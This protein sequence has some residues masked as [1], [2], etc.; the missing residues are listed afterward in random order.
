M[1]LSLSLPRALL[2][3]LPAILAVPGPASGI[4]VGPSLAPS[5]STE[6][7]IHAE[8]IGDRLLIQGVFVNEGLTA[9]TLRYEL[10]VRRSGD[11]GTTRTTQSGAFATES[12][13]ADTLSTT[14]V[15]VQSGDTTNLH[16]LVRRAGAL[17]DS[18]R[19]RRTVP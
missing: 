18:A 19:V 7:Q 3:L 11:T 6:A 1:N 10:S 14:T 5:D 12:G 2:S 8:R 9:D 4:P 13:Q 15:N 17:L 16:L